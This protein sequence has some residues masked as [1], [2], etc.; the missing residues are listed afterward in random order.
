MEN[1][2]RPPMPP[3][4]RRPYFAGLP[5]PEARGIVSI[6]V[7]ASGK[8]RIDYTDGTSQTL[9]TVPQDLSALAAF[10]QAAADQAA[11]DKGSIAKAANDAQDALEDVDLE[12]QAEF[13]AS[14]QDEA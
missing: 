8:W 10:V 5:D 6:M 3:P 1:N 9:D 11:Q 4:A 12:R 13:H 2:R 7:L 14:T